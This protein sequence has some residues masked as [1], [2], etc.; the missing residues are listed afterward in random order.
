MSFVVGAQPIA[1]TN[2]LNFAS[3]ERPEVMRSFSDVIDGIKEACETFE[4][5]RSFRKR[6]RSITKPKAAG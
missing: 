3:P 1:V 5:A 4:N 6:F 2:C